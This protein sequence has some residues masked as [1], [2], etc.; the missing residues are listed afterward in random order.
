[1]LSTS[2]RHQNL[3]LHHHDYDSHLSQHFHRNRHRHRQPSITIPISTP[4]SKPMDC[5]KAPAPY[6]SPLSQ[7]STIWPGE[8]ALVFSGLYCI[9]KLHQP[10]EAIVFLGIG[11]GTCFL[12][13]ATHYVRI[14]LLVSQEVEKARRISEKYPDTLKFSRHKILFDR[15]LAVARKM[16]LFLFMYVLAYTPTFIASVY[17]WATGYRAPSA[18]DYIGGFGLHLNNIVNPLVYFLIAY[19]QKSRC[20]YKDILG[21]NRG[22]DA[23]Q[24][25]LTEVHAEEN[26][27]CW[28]AIDNLL[29]Q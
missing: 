24:K 22:K 7:A 1:M 5:T 10:F 28:R 29:E 25:Y 19:Y 20:S 15:N 11:V 16:S 8:S 2:N 23:L 21:T 13:S 18:L 17:E 14:Y 3:H 26:I 6:P 4:I 9:P 12:F 27:M